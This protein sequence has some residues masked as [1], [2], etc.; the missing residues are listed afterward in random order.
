MGCINSKP[1]APNDGIPGQDQ[2]A[3]DVF[4]KLFLSDRDITE[5]HNSFCDIDTRQAHYIKIRDLH[6]Y[7]HLEDTFINRKIWEVFE[8]DELHFLHY[9]CSVSPRFALVSGLC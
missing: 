4:T 5:L 2:L 1:F 6:I 9:V 3:V 7:F 8:V